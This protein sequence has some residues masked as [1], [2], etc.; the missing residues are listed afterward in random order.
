MVGKLFKSIVVGTVSI[1]VL[2]VIVF[3]HWFG[4]KDLQEMEAY[5]NMPTASASSTQGDV[6]LTG[7]PAG[8]WLAEQEALQAQDSSKNQK[9]KFSK[10]TREDIIQSLRE[11]TSFPIANSRIR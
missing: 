11:A 3:Q 6:D 8:D 2:Y 10:S 5:D 1:V 7:T 4:L 9:S